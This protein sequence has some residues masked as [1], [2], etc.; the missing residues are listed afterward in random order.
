MDAVFANEK[1]QQWLEGKEIVKK[2]YVPG[3]LVSVVVK[4]R[5]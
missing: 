5:K 4:D 3:K 2:I 1:I